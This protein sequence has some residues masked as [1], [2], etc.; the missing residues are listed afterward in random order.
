MRS[1]YSVRGSAWDHKAAGLGLE[2]E[3]VSPA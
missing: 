3:R 2:D 1:D